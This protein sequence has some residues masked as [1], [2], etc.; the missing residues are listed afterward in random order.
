VNQ[1]LAPTRAG[2]LDSAP[3]VWRGVT[4]VPIVLG[5]LLVVTLLRLWFA[6]RFEL[7]PDE[8]YYWLWSKHLAASYRDKGPAIA[9]T[10]A[11]GTRLFGDTAFGIRFFAVLLSTATGWLIFSLARRLYGDRTALW[12]LVVALVMPLFAVGAILM[13]IDSLSVFSWAWA[14]VVFWRVLQGRSTA[15]WWWLGLIIGFGF[16]A[17]FTNGVQLACIGLFLLWSREHRPFLFGREMLLLC[18]AFVLSITPILWWNVQTG[19]VHALALHSRSGVKESFQVHPTELLQ[20][21]GGQCAVVS[22]LFM[23]GIAV[24]A[25]VLARQRD[26]DLRTRFLLSQFFPLYG[27]FLFFSL[28]KAGKANWTAPALV[29]GIVLG[30]IFWRNLAARRPVWRWGIGAAFAVATLT[31]AILHHT[32][33]L[34][35]PSQ[36]D[37]GRRAKGW[38][39]FANHVERARQAYEANLLICHHY[40][41]A[42]LITFYLPDHPTTFLPP[43]PYGES[44]FTLWPGYNVQSD[45][46]ALYVTTP[47]NPPPEPLRHQFSDIQLVDDFWS[48]HNE[49][50]MTHFR[51]YLCQCAGGTPAS[52]PESGTRG[53]HILSSAIFH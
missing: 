25:F 50:P 14:L 13:T 21:V 43:K 38:T 26:G 5:V 46:R 27:V 32:E 34:G 40:G 45:T 12:C 42:S 19:W 28:N 8:A 48:Q 7:V 51:I 35:L 47:R 23:A 30:V 6:T 16:L 2:Q 29:T 17:K 4:A 11:L 1:D 53:P 39:D 33:L 41:Q 31:T 22:P 15:R 18:A 20:F 49:R 52:P 36:L 10:I 44:Q 3:F 9:W 24:A 37:P